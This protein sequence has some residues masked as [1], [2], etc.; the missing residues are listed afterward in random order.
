MNITAASVHL[1]GLRT[2][3][4]CLADPVTNDPVDSYCYQENI[5][6]YGTNPGQTGISQML[7]ENCYGDYGGKHI[8]GFTDASLSR[9]IVVANCQAEQGSPYVAFGGQTCWVDYSGTANQNGTATT[10]VPKLYHAD[11]RRA[12]SVRARAASTVA[13]TGWLSHN[14]GGRRSVR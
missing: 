11:E 13:R 12:S 8:F 2:R 4:T 6:T 5:G 1:N 7:F 3:K 14:N 9:Q 10:G